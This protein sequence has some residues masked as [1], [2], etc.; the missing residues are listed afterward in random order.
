MGAA[1]VWVLLPEGSSAAGARVRICNLKNKAELNGAEGTL[2]SKVPGKDAY[3]L[4]LDKGG[5]MVKLFR[6]NLEMLQGSGSAVPAASAV[7][8]APAPAS[9]AASSMAAGGVWV[10]VP[11]GTP[12]GVRVWICNLK[13]KAE[14]NGGEGTLMSKVPGKDAYEL[15]LDK[16]GTMVKLFRQNLEML[17]GSASAPT[18]APA[19]APAPVAEATAAGVWVPVLEGTSA[20]GARV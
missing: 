13:N 20:S 5:T 16:G 17:Q 10:P 3:E 6:Q 14:L 1:G 2:V 18:A 19:P 12:A 11:E 7:V 8:P 15:R 4:R 9:V